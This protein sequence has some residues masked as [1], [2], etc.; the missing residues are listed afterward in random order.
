MWPHTDANM[1]TLPSTS[2]ATLRSKSIC[3]AA[4]TMVVESRVA[5]NSRMCS[6]Y[7]SRGATT[8]SGQT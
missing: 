1:F 8:G 6:Q 7:R 5:A 2:N 3:M 4:P